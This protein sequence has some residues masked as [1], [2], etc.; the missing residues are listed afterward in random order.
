MDNLI[1]NDRGDVAAVLDWELS[2][3]GDPLSD[4]AYVRKNDDAWTLL[5]DRIIMYLEVILQM[6]GIVCLGLY[7]M[8][9]CMHCVEPDVLPPAPDKRLHEGPRGLRSRGPGHPLHR[10]RRPG[11]RRG[12][13]DR[14]PGPP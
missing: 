5:L 4:L 1:F 14:L 7:V 3:L 13:R 11:L 6:P 2:T 8:Y 9:A 12:P 10:L